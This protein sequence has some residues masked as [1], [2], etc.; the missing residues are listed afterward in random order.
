MCVLK[1]I[2]NGFPQMF[3]K[4]K[5]VNG[6]LNTNNSV[7][8][9]DFPY[10]ITITHTKLL[11]GAGFVYLVNTIRI[12]FSH[13][14]ARQPSC[15]RCCYLPKNVHLLYFMFVWSTPSCCQSPL[16]SPILVFQVS[17]CG[18]TGPCHAFTLNE[19]DCV[20]AWQ[21]VERIRKYS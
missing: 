10:H 2:S 7:P 14:M 4:K 3:S 6:S 20:A 9:K 15:L 21:F 17:L 16:Y 13:H 18:H 11:Q 1:E 8:T 12:V 19:T 5:N